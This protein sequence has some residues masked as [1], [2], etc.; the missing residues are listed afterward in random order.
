MIEFKIGLE[1][2]TFLANSKGEL[3]ITPDALPHDDFPLLAEFRAEPGTDVGTVVGNFMKTWINTRKQIADF[4]SDL[5]IRNSGYERVD[6][7]TWKKAM[8]A[9]GSKHVDTSLNV[10]DM[11]TSEFSDA[12][13]TKG[14]ITHRYVSAGLHVHF[15]AREVCKWTHPRMLT[16]GGKKNKKL[17]YM[18]G[19]ETLEVGSLNL[20]TPS[21]LIKEI[22]RRMDVEVYPYYVDASMKLHCKYRQPGFYEPKPWGFEYRSLPF[23]TSVLS[24]LESIVKK[25]FDIL[26]DVTK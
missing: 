6:I 15:S 7:A 16:D 22:V 12:V 3:V 13:I 4:N 24:S 23:N 9:A 19:T 2:E 14:R 18:Q 21:M 1:A 20:L 17:Y 25:S 11:D 8:L 5:L 10:Y 26:T